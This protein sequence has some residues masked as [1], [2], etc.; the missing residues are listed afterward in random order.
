MKQQQLTQAAQKTMR[1][2]LYARVSKE[3]QNK[4]DCVSIDEQIDQMHIFCERSG[5]N[6]LAEYT[7]AE[8]YKATQVPKKGRVVNP[9]GER[10][11]RPQFLAMLERIKAGDADIVLYWRDDRLVRH[12]RVASALEDALDLGDKERGTRPS[13]KLMD[14]AGVVLDRFVLHIKAAIWR[15]ENK[16]RVERIKLGKVGTLK[17]GQWPGEY[18]RYG[19]GTVKE[20]GRR[21][22]VIILNPDEARAVEMVFHWYDAGMTMRDISTELVKQ[23]VEQKGFAT[24]HEWNAKLISSMLRC[25]DYTGRA[26][27]HFDDGTEYTITIPQIITPELWQRIQEKIDKNKVMATRNAKGVYLLQGILYCADCGGKVGPKAI[28]YYLGYKRKDGTRKRYDKEAFCYRCYTGDA[29]P[30]EHARP[31]QWNGEKLDWAVWRY[32]VDNGIKHP[33][34]IQEQILTRQAALRAQ[35][36]SV[37]G[38]IAHAR[39]KLAAIDQ[40]RAAYQRQNAREQITDAEFDARMQETKDARQHWQEELARLRELR[41]DTDKVTHGLAYVTELM[42]TLETI[43]PEIDLE[44]EVLKAMPK[45]KRFEI[46]KD[47]QDV[48]RAL[49]DRVEISARGK[50]DIVGLLD[51]SEAAH[52]ELASSKI[53]TLKLSFR[54]EFTLADMLFSQAIMSQGEVQNV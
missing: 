40:E 28:R 11:D 6:I 38:D 4:D 21:G 14:T 3:D 17:Q 22:R 18:W 41:D 43:L 26:T 37:N 20:S 7:D 32:V 29:F 42:G 49:C 44:P 36:E 12:P 19:Y 8:N 27:W 25:E 45:E 50:V 30:H 52:F 16:R 34:L 39:Q 2:V 48:I 15:E 51:G 54:F 1:A 35:G 53:D 46:L 31:Y 5:W 13:I 23:G 33:E 47:R 10:A 9:S 24:R